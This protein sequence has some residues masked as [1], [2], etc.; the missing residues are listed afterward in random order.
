MTAIDLS[1]DSLRQLDISPVRVFLE[2]LNKEDNFLEF[3]QKL[4]FNI[5]FPREENDPRELSEIPEIRLWFIRLDSV[6]PWLPFFLNWQEGE[7]ARYTAMLIPH[8]FSKTEGIK[9]NPESL[10]IFVMQKIFILNDWLKRKNIPTKSRLKSMT[11][12]LGYEI[13][14]AFFDIV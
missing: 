13:E 3:E 7:L 4:N 1:H 10:E 8:Q 14:D 11:Q 9:Y 2:K 6:C 5:D 12:V